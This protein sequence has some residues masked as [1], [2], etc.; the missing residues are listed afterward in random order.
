MAF[1]VD[2][3]TVDPQPEVRLAMLD[4]GTSLINAYGESMVDA[5]LPPIEDVLERSSAAGASGRVG[6][7]EA[8]D[9]DWQREGA[10][11]LAGRLARHLGKDDARIVNIIN[12]LVA[13]LATPSQSV[14]ESAAVRCL[15][16]TV[17]FHANHAHS[18]TRSP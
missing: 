7:T 13:S 15:L 5:M 9:L 3:G 10:T 16:F 17:T 2:D 1:V 4:A 18:L 12:L 6:R 14:Q 11:V 8:Q